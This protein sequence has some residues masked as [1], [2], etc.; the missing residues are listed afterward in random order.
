MRARVVTSAS[1]A[2]DRSCSLR[3]DAKGCR[4]L[5]GV[6]TAADG[7]ALRADASERLVPVQVDVT[8]VGSVVQVARTVSAE[9]GTNRRRH[10]GRLQTQAPQR[11]L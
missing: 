9:F 10:R 6:R 1:S 11:P 4:V 5:A 3:C 7:D 8:V 2:I